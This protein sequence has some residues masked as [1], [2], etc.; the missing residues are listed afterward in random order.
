MPGATYG[1]FK[2]KCAAAKCQEA[3]TRGMG[4]KCLSDANE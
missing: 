3:Q 4:P 2:N 1:Y